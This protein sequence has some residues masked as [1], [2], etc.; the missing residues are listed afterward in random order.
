MS[1][2]KP[3][4]RS[5]RK[6]TLRKQIPESLLARLWR[7]RAARQRNFRTTEGKR[8]RILYPGRQGVEAGPDFRDALIFREGTGLVRG[9]VELHLHPKDW[10]RHGHASDHRYNSVVLHGVLAP[11]ES[12]QPLPNGGSAPAVGLQSL[13]EFSSDVEAPRN[14]NERGVLWALLGSRGYPKPATR[15]VALRLLERAGRARFLGKSAGFP[16]LIEE[17][18]PHESLYRSLMESLG[19]S[20]NRTGF[21][22]LARRVPYSTLVK[23]TSGVSK[24]EPR[25]NIGEI[26]LEAAGFAK[27]TGKILHPRAVMDKKLWRLFRIRPANHPRRRVSG[28]AILICRTASFGLLESAVRWARAGA[29]KTILQNL[30]VADPAGGPAFIGRSRALDMAVNVFLPLVHAHAGRGQDSDLADEALSLFMSAP[31][32]QPTRITREMEDVLFPGPWRPLGNAPARQQG[33]LHLHR[34]MQGEG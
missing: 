29:F 7:E 27:P 31:K 10:D 25:H 26:L 15:T 9:D 30:C 4:D 22:E 33:L 5:S 11:P 6:K 32:L 12:S 19:Y 2:H 13:L 24:Q 18:G 21:L 14:R 34:L 1:S 20:E 16:S 23:E 28:A 8:V 3:V 17:I